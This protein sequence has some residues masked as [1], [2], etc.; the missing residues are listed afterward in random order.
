MIFEDYSIEKEYDCS[1]ITRCAGFT[2]LMVLVINTNKYPELIKDIYLYKDIINE[3]NDLGWTALI[4]ACR[5]SSIET[6]KQLLD[7]GADVNL[8]CNGGWN[9]LMVSC[10]NNN[11]NTT[12]LLLDY[13]ADVNIKDTYGQNAYMLSPTEKIKQ[14]KKISICSN[15]KS[16][17]YK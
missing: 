1:P 13:G 10:N 8:R 17:K 16:D 9:A 4:L 15:F 11:F 7:N 2:K 6:I 5:N 3:K 14:L 12:K